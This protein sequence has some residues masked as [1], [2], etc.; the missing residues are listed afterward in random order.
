MIHCL[1]RTGRKAAKLVRPSVASTMRWSIS[2]AGST[3]TQLKKIRC[4]MLGAAGIR[5]FA[6]CPLTAFRLEW[7]WQ[8]DPLIAEPVAL[9]RRYLRTLSAQPRL[10]KMLGQAWGTQRL[11]TFIESSGRTQWMR[12]TGPVTA[13]ISTLRDLSWKVVGPCSFQSPQG[14]TFDLRDDVDTLLLQLAQAASAAE[15]GHASKQHLGGCIEQGIDLSPAK[16]FIAKLRRQGEHQA[17]GTAVALVSAGLWFKARLEEEPAKQLCRIC[18]RRPETEEHLFWECASPHLAAAGCSAEV[19][20][21]TDQYRAEAQQQLQLAGPTGDPKQEAF[22]CRGIML[23]PRAP[24]EP[25]PL[26]NQSWRMQKQ[27]S[28]AWPAQM[29]AEVS[30]A[31]RRAFAVVLGRQFVPSRTHNQK[32]GWASQGHSWEK[33]SRYHEQS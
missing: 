11:Q 31:A 28:E 17:A 4:S 26:E 2:V 15:L 27:S 1:Q 5:Y 7:S 14:D 30:T 32:T 33:P 18:G 9:L 6:R 19:L 24:L 10:R 23:L 25:P 21:K 8:V 12:T 20:E 16:A 3:R 22:W 29:A 13:V